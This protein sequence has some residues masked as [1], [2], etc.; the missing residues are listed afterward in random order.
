VKPKNI[1]LTKEGIAKL[2]DLGLARAM[3]DKEA[4]ETSEHG[5]GEARYGPTAKNRRF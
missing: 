3:D 4:A 5:C 1:L 2:T